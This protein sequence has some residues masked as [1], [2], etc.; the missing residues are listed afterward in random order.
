MCKA[1]EADMELRDI[2]YDACAQLALENDKEFF[3]Y[4][5]EQ[6][7]CRIPMKSDIGQCVQSPDELERRWNTYQWQGCIIFDLLLLHIQYLAK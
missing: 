2:L 6:S 4:N 3:S 5:E 7:R 1:E